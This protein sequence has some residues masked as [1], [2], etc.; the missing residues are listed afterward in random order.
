MGK[1]FFAEPAVVSAPLVAA[2]QTEPLNL[3]RTNDHKLADIFVVNDIEK[4]GQRVQWCAALSGAIVSTPLYLLSN[5]TKGFALK[6]K[7]A[8]S[9][10]RSICVT[11]QFRDLHPVLA[12]IIDHKVLMTLSKWQ[13]LPKAE[14]LAKVAGVARPKD[15]N[16]CVVFLSAREQG[17]AQFSG[18]LL[19]LTAEDA[20]TWMTTIDEKASC[21]NL[22]QG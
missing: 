21:K 6:F 17:S 3:C 16:A 20:L 5:C 13:T 11:E 19:K 7:P 10:R 2:L 14:V 12:S 15:L 1:L 9:T 8:L 22:C 18:V 4:K